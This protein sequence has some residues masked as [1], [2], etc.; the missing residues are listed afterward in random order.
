MAIGVYPGSYDPLTNGHL[1]VLKRALGI[2]DEVILLLAV[3]PEKSSHFS[4]EERLEMMK[5]ATE[6]IKGVRV[7]YTPGLT[8]DYC[9]SVGSRH[10]IRG[11]RAVTDFEYEHALALTNEFIDDSVDMVFFMA[12]KR[13]SF[14]SSSNVISLYKS[15]VDVSSLVPPA[16]YEAI[17]N[18]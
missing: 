1:E 12:H 3:N 2:F 10:I 7:D 14:I 5:K 6:G 18:K 17:K 15:G 9:K 11:L 13:E 8:V 16:V 4:V